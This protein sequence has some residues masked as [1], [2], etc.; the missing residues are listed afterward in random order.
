MSPPHLFLHLCFLG[1]SSISFYLQAFR[2]EAIFDSFLFFSHHASQYPSHLQDL[3]LTSYI[4]KTIHSLTSNTAHLCPHHLFSKWPQQSPNWPFAHLVLAMQ[5]ESS[6]KGTNLI[7]FFL[8]S[9]QALA[10]A[11]LSCFISHYLLSFMHQ[12]QELLVSWVII[13]ALFPSTNTSCAG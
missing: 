8:Q 4:L 10:P 11:H 7:S 13:L 2:L 9:S 1:P 3:C 12:P 5:P 6:F